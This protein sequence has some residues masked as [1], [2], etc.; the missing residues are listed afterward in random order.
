MQVFYLHVVHINIATDSS[1][2]AIL[3]KNLQ[4]F[5]FPNSLQ[6]IFIYGH[7]HKKTEYI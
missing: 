5:Y 4:K 2:H 6:H 1:N 7:K 3:L